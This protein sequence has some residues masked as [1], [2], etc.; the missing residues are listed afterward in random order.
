MTTPRL[1]RGQYQHETATI[2]ATAGALGLE[3][4]PE[5]R[6]LTEESMERL[7]RSGKREMLLRAMSDLGKTEIDLDVLHFVRPALQG[8]SRIREK[9]DA[10]RGKTPDAIAAAAVSSYTL[11]LSGAASELRSFASWWN[12]LPGEYILGQLV[13][14]IEKVMRRL[15]HAAA[16]LA[17]MTESPVPFPKKTDIDALRGAYHELLSETRGFGKALETI[18]SQVLLPAVVKQLGK[19]EEVLG[20]LEKVRLDVGK[21]LSSAIQQFDL[22]AGSLQR[23]LSVDSLFESYAPR[24]EE[25]ERAFLDLA[26]GKQVELSPELRQWVAA[27]ALNTVQDL[28]TNRYESDRELKRLVADQQRENPFTVRAHNLLSAKLI[29]GRRDRERQL[30]LDALSALLRL[31]PGEGGAALRREIENKFLQMTAVDQAKT[32][33]MP[34]V[35]A[36]TRLIDGVAFLSSR[37]GGPNRVDARGVAAEIV[38]HRQRIEAENPDVPKATGIARTGASQ[39]DGTVVFFVRGKE[40]L[41]PAYSIDYGMGHPG[42]SYGLQP[43]LVVSREQL[44]LAHFRV[45]DRVSEQVEAYIREHVGSSAIPITEG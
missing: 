1:A 3:F 36:V 40:P 42:F 13:V 25:V 19:V 12:A 23:I 14:R 17:K 41:Y 15:N 21:E 44:T 34:S 20:S 29:E 30:Q 31:Y 4:N 2:D 27:V 39:T 24:A 18:Y 35:D 16:E 32:G 45:R 5:T 28:F 26:L 33:R 22:L 43:P 6:L 7:Q 10:Y 11:A 8:K 38:E 9:I 37:P